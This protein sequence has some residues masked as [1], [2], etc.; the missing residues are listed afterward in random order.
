MN[1][2]NYIISA[3]I[4]F[5][6]ALSS[7]VYSVFN[8]MRADNVSAVTVGS[9]NPGH[10][11]DQM[12]CSASTLCIDTSSGRVGIGTS[13]PAQ[14]LEI[15]GNI[16][17]SGDICNGAGA[18]LSQ[19][20]SFIGSQPIGGGTD[21]SREQCTSA[22]GTLVDVGLLNPICRFNNVSTC[23]TGWHQTNNWSTTI[24]TYCA[25]GTACTA[26]SSPYCTTSYHSWSDTLP[27]TCDYYHM[28]GGVCP[29]DTCTATITQIGCY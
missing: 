26:Y 15:S 2:K 22:G 23:P 19:I 11:W 13:A 18:C 28:S 14:K 16:L 17:A 21:H 27:E 25:Q 8:A 1:K 20:N 24:P 10:S 6:L 12:E 29:R 7:G 5:I 4:L 9:P 3:G